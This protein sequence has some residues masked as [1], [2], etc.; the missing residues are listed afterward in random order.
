MVEQKDNMLININKIGNIAISEDVMKR[1]LIRYASN[2]N[3]HKL[4]NLKIECSKD[5]V[6]FFYFKYANNL[7]TS[8]IDDTWSFSNQIKKFIRKNLALEHIVIVVESG[9]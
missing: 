1:L 3:N 6:F 4:L 5:E 9:Y 8:F 2:L 7:S